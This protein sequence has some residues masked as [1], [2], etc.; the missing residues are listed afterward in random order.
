MRRFEKIHS[1]KIDAGLN[2]LACKGCG[3]LF[4]KKPRLEDRLFHGMAAMPE[5]VVECPLCKNAENDK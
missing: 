4:V 1:D 2:I 5:W 3:I